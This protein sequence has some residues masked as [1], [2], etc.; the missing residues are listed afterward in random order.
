MLEKNELTSSTQKHTEKVTESGYFVFLAPLFVMIQLFLEFGALLFL[1]SVE[2]SEH[3]VSCLLKNRVSAS[4]TEMEAE[5]R[6]PNDSR[7]MEVV[8]THRG[9]VASH[10]SRLGRS[11]EE[12]RHDEDSYGGQGQSGLHLL[13]K[14]AFAVCS[15][16]VNDWL[17]YPRWV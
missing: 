3:F 15:I 10:S 6:I 5:G 8:S 13:R 17:D 7:V 11:Q 12:D 1:E 16:S 2:R 14:H 4:C 9:R